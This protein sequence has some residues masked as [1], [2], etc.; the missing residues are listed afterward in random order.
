MNV[1][2]I[3]ENFKSKA[4]INREIVSYILPYLDLSDTHNEIINTIENIRDTIQGG[5][6]TELVW[7]S[8]TVDFFKKYSDEISKII[9]DFIQ[10]CGSDVFFKIFD[11]GDPLFRDDSNRNLATWFATQSILS[12]LVYEIEYCNEQVA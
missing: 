1:Y 11:V 8:D 3:I 10:E 12:E 6:I 7:F 9:S 2:N 5:S 4:E